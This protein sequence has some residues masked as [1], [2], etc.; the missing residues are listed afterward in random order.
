MTKQALEPD[1]E[2]Q[3]DDRQIV[4][5]NNIQAPGN[6][7]D[8]LRIVNLY[9]DITEAKADA[10]VSALLFLENTS[11]VISSQSSEDETSEEIL[12][13]RDIKLYISTNGGS[14]SEMFSVIDV[15]DSIKK[16]TCDIETVGIGKVMSAGV[17]ILASGTP[18]KRKIGKNCRVMLH[19]VV[20][21]HSGSIFALENEL[22]EI[23]WVQNQY[24]RCLAKK[25]KM[26]EARI[27]KILK[28]EKDVYISAKDA[29]KFGIADEII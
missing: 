4:I 16:R 13:N 3:V 20:S 15:I 9:G 8:D 12:I 5:I 10:I 29:I 2:P 25:T 14:A 28:T 19:N 1:S 27:K 18:G 11:P 22:E 23:R 24:V 7:D 26:T 17:L 21:G 6:P